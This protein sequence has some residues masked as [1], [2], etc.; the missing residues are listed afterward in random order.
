MAKRK[1]PAPE[2]FTGGFS[3]IPHAVLDSQAFIG[4]TDRGKSLLFALIRQHN[5]KN[6]GHLHLTNQ[7]L[8]SH[9]WRSASMNKQTIAELVERGLIVTTRLGGLNAG[10]NWYALTWLSIS[11][12]KELDISSSNYHKG[13]WGECKLPPTARRKPPEKQKKP[14]G[15]RNSTVPVIGTAKDST[16]PVVGTKTALFPRIA[17]PVY[18]NNV[19]KPCTTSTERR[20]GK[21]IV[22]KSRKESAH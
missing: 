15:D 14:S 4:L 17:V 6:N 20:K 16:V 13:A 3:R 5:G 7:W 22:G 1:E 8:A 10:C 9:G 2:S 21:R 12:F 11:D 19:F 18:G